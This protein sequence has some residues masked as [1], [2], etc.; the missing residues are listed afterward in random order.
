MRSS[1]TR[2]GI[3][4][5]LTVLW[6]SSCTGPPVEVPSSSSLVPP[7]T[8][9]RYFFSGSGIRG[10]LEVSQ[11]PPSICYSTQSNPIR[12]ISII[13]WS[14]KMV[15]PSPGVESYAEVSYAPRTNDFCD[16]K[17]RP[18][19]VAAMIA[20]PSEHVVRW[21]PSDGSPIAVSPLTPVG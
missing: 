2:L 18:A 11:M 5:A 12:P 19:L 21:R 9:A 15:G 10:V 6:L 7:V 20:N 8:F 13:R 17:A 14:D 4:T 16:R 1:R 3:G